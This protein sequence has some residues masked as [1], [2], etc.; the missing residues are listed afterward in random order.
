M[1][2]IVICISA[3]RRDTYHKDTTTTLPVA[4]APVKH[5]MFGNIPRCRDALA[6]TSVVDIINKQYFFFLCTVVP[7]IPSPNIPIEKLEGLDN[8]IYQ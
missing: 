3:A 7:F 8:I 4:A 6:P 2:L 1:I 5:D